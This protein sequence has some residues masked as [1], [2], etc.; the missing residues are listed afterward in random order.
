MGR[1]YKKNFDQ[2]ISR[3][4][5]INSSA[6]KG[7]I[8]QIN[9]IQDLSR[10]EAV[11]KVKP[12]N[13]WD[14]DK[15]L[16]AF[17]DALIE[18]E[19][20]IWSRRVDVEDDCI[21]SLSPRYGIAEHSAYIGGKVLMEETTSYNTPFIKEWGDLR[22]IA[23]DS[24]NVWFRR[25]IDGISYIKE[26]G[27]GR[28]A[29][30]LRGG[31]G[32]AELANF[33]R[34]N[35]LFTDFYDYPDEVAEMIEVCVKAERWFMQSQLEALGDFEGGILDGFNVWMP[36]GSFG[37]LSED[38]S[39]MCS[40]GMYR[41]FGQRYTEKMTEGFDNILMHV[42]SG[43]AHILPDLTKSKNLTYIQISADPNQ[44]TAIDIFKK[45]E[46]C[47]RGKIVMM[48]TTPEEL[49]KEA[50]FLKDKKVIFTID[51]ES[52]AE[53]QRITEYVRTQFPI[54]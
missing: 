4:R 5:Q 23:L 19:D 20:F 30:R 39:Y 7:A 29:A 9:T 35:D 46:E 26:K 28:I 12:L 11:P 22:K 21:P 48:M 50:E 2:I 25:V 6:S 43:G 16:C 37:H 32:P 15:E 41:E 49:L 47:L 44:P 31:C 42:H 14:F 3:Y 17:W 10:L 36:H 53:A 13:A 27:A 51:C 52:I 40:P 34:G 45:Y 33:I 1:Y 8:L 54:C 18:R 38:W 24:D